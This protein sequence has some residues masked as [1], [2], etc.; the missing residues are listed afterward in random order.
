MAKPYREPIDTGT[1]E[2]ARRFTIVPTL[3]RGPQGGTSGKVVDETEIDR[4]LL[5]DAITP[6]E[7]SVLEALLKRL[8]KASFIGIKSPNYDAR[9][10][11]DPTIISD[12]KAAS[13]RSVVKLFTLMDEDKK[14]GRT[15]RAAL[16][17]LVLVDQ[18][19]NET[20]GSIKTAVSAL[21]GILNPR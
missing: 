6:A 2:L 3:S 5:R 1:G 7:H 14:I 15:R 11:A 8:H 20:L 4:M 9:V 12:K 10:S 21:Q 17:N 16:V 13:I 19:W 18:P